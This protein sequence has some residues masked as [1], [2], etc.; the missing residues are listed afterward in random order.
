VPR[1]VTEPDKLH[2][3]LKRWR[4][5]EPP[6]RGHRLISES[7]SSCNLPNTHRDSE[8]TMNGYALWTSLAIWSVVLPLVWLF[9]TW[10]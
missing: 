6:I 9:W 4:K 2:P 5:P 8:A 7:I 1:K 10:P 3:M